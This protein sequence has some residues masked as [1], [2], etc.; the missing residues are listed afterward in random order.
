M[1]LGFKTGLVHW[2]VGAVKKFICHGQCLQLVFVGAAAA[3]ANPTDVSVLG[4]RFCL[5]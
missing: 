1:G 2:D 5:Y 3:M 4:F